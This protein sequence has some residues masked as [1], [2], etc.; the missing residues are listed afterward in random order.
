MAKNEDYNKILRIVLIIQLIYM[1]IMGV[2]SAITFLMV[3]EYLSYFPIFILILI[4]AVIFIALTVLGAITFS[5]GE[6]P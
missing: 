5:S 6:T 2:W 3:V 4:W 1:A